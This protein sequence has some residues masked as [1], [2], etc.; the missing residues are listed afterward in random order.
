MTLSQKNA[1]NMTES[2]GQSWKGGIVKKKKTEPKRSPIEEWE[3]V[4][5]ICVFFND[6][7]MKRAKKWGKKRRAQGRSHKLKD[8]IWSHLDEVLYAYGMDD[9]RTQYFQWKREHNDF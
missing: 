6:D 9:V 5:S 2:S 8:F 3:Y 4:F 1:Y 7:L